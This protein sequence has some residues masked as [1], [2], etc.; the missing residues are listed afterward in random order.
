[1]ISMV[2]FNLHVDEGILYYKNLMLALHCDLVSINFV[3]ILSHK[4]IVKK[5]PVN[6]YS[7]ACI[8]FAHRP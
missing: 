5:A 8:I 7:Q 1:M 4:F 2:V 6:N 3:I